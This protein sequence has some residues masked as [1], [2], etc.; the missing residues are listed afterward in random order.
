MSG[1]EQSKIRRYHVAVAVVA[2]QTTTYR[3]LAGVVWFTS[4]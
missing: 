3:M 4:N 2:S 1:G